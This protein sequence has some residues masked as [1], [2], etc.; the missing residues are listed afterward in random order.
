MRVRLED[1]QFQNALGAVAGDLSSFA[2][3]VASQRAA[4]S[5]GIVTITNSIGSSASSTTPSRGL[6]LFRINS[7][8]VAN[9]PSGIQPITAIISLSATR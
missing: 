6:S 7:S 8:D 2:P 1:G 5:V 9:T 4:S 3:E